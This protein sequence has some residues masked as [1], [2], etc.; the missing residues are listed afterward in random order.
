MTDYDQILFFNEGLHGGT[1][2]VGHQY[3]K[4]N[5]PGTPFYDPSLPEKVLISFDAT[6]LYGDIL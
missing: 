5:I 2:F 1:A 4:A 6:N 3:A